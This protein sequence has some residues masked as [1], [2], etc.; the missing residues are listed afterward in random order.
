MLGALLACAAAPQSA[1]STAN[2]TACAESV[3]VSLVALVATPE[4]FAG[5]CVRTIGY[6]HLEFEGNGLYIHRDDYRQ[7]IYKNG[8]WLDVEALPR[9]SRP[10][11][12]DR[13]VIVEGIVDAASH[14]H[15]GAWSA[16]IRDISRLDPWYPIEVDSLGRVHIDS[17]AQ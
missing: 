3:S 13:Y 14:G 10:E 2:L 7:D 5:R 16:S 4:R 12:N 1:L 8:V 6:M 11:I 15:M 17:T 9:G